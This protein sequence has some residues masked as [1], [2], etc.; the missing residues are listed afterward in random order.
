MTTLIRRPCT[1]AAETSVEK[2]PQRKV[3]IGLFGIG[4]DTYWPQFA[5][6][7]ERLLGYQA[8]IADRLR[9]FGADLTD[10]GMID[11]PAKAREAAEAFGREQ[12]D[13]IF[14]NISTYA[15][16]STV[17]PIVQ[18]VGVPFVLL[19]LQPVAQLDYEAFN[20][21]GDRGRMTGLWLEHCQ[22]CSAPE[23]ACVLNRAEIP[24]RMVTG[25]LQDDA[26]WRKSASGSMRPESPPEC[27][28]TASAFWAIITAECSMSTP[29]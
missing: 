26:A 6:L 12:V 7:R 22:S 11:N 4:L 27:G 18:S 28:P 20:R 1:E 24:C 25:H 10:L 2:P 19:N 17:L 3:R 23:I 8:Q 13:L 14:L 15:L 29:I 21:L 9:E 16:S 5:G